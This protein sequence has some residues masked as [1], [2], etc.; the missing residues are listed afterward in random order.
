M[1]KRLLLIK[2]LKQSFFLF[3]PRGTG[4]TSWIQQ[5]F[6]DALYIDLLKTRDYALLQAD[7]S[8]L[9]TMVLGHHSPWT[10]I[11]EVQ[12]IPALLDEV[13]R[14]IENHQ[15]CFIL[16]GSS[17]RKLK[18]GGA[19]LLAGRAILY[20]MHPLTATEIGESF[21]VIKALQYGLLPYSYL[22]DNSKEFL[23]S[24][25]L[26]YL[27]EEVLQ[28]G[29]VRNVGSFNRF[30]EIASFSQGNQLNLTAIAQE[31][32][33]SQKIVREYFEIL[34]DLLIAVQIPCFTKRAQRKLVQHPKFYYFDAG[35]YQYIRPRGPLDIPE[36]VGG[37]AFETLFLQHLRAII[38]YE[39][40]DLKI[41]FWRTIT[42][43]EIDFI[44]Y[45]EN[46][47]FAF[48]LKSTRYFRKKD[49]SALKIFKS[50]YA[51]AQC[52]L[53]YAGDHVEKHDEITVLPI[54]NALLQLPIILKNGNYSANTATAQ[55]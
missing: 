23:E 51:I 34:E 11:D 22:H 41:Y 27:K 39:R 24:Y 29:L 17:A 19:N 49:L 31:C 7:P 12:K 46:G 48:E 8:R 45:G 5:H 1:L 16:S 14:L 9:E 15:R 55:I 13:H 25:M 52:Y 2:N 42:Q 20:H 33:I 50:D 38:D 4:K 37:A 32:G 53:I 10:I 21:D 30:I 40:L 26:T 35:V 3:G 18:R 44:V 6:S 47:L 36:E 43:V 54:K 28:E